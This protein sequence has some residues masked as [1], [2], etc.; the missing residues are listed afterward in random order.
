MKLELKD[1]ISVIICC[2]NSSWIIIRCLD[3]LIKQRVPIDF[4]WEIVLVDNN[5][6]DDTCQIA[7]SFMQNFGVDFQIVK[8]PEPG[9]LN[10]R[11][12]GI[13]EVK[14]QYTIYCDDDNLLDENYVY[15]A[16]QIMKTYPDAGAF[17]GKGIP[18]FT[19]TPEPEVMEYIGGYAVG[20]QKNKSYLFGAGITV[21]TEIVKEIY[22]NQKFY[23]TGRKGNV[24]LAGDDSELVFSLI[25]RGY[26][27]YTSDDVTYIHVLATKRLTFTYLKSMIHGFGLS[28]PILD[29]YEAVFIHQK[30]NALLS[31]FFQ[32]TGSYIK[33]SLKK[34]SLKRDFIQIK[35]RGYFDGLR[36]WGYKTLRHIYIYIQNLQSQYADIN[37]DN[38]THYV[39]TQCLFF[40]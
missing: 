5:C 16:Y 4:K 37:I 20:S 39:V 31:I 27:L 11:I 23:L 18:E 28:T 7:E 32:K 1:G 17:G 36:L 2:Y 15:V 19:T 8:Q 14:Y 33:Q 38:K 34:P 21:K 35:N 12:K 25:L 3:A 22:R 26:K 40:K 30:K 9:L 6:S 29:L 24:L 10:A 13:N